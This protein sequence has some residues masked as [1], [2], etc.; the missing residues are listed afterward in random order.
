MDKD[1]QREIRKI[2]N[3]IEDKSAD[4]DYI[5]RG[6]PEKHKEEPHCGK[7]SSSLWRAIAKGL[8]DKE[9]IEII[10][11]KEVQT[12]ILSTV[13]NYA[14]GTTSEG[15]FEIMGNL[16]HY[17][18]KT[19]LIDFTTDY[20]IA[21]FFAC[22]GSLCESG[23]VILLEINDETNEKYCIKKPQNPI[24]RVISQKSIFVQPP[25]GFIAV[26]PKDEITIPKCLKRP[27]LDYL[28]KYHDISNEIIYNDFH[29]FIKHQKIHHNAYI[30]F[31]I[32]L[33]YQFGLSGVGKE[34]GRE[35]RK[36]RFERAIE[37]FDKAIEQNPNF[38]EAYYYRGSAYLNIGAAC[39][40]TKKYDCAIKDLDEAIRLNPKYEEAYNVR[41]LVYHHKGEYGCAIK[42]F[43][44]AV[45]L[46][47]D[48]ADAYNN[49]GVVYRDKGEYDRA[50]Q[51]FNRAIELNRD[52]ADA[53]CHRGSAY[54]KK[55]EFTHAIV[56]LN[57]TIAINPKNQLARDLRDKAQRELK[58]FKQKVE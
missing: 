37:Y 58:K 31:Y 24:N 56:D 17:G 1:I 7:V 32:G 5:Y 43:D 19:N 39:Q 22:D 41:G 47:R 26:K 57:K 53:Y 20:L 14:N 16:Q 23:R 30:D 50:I 28:R 42:D 4:G 49:R 55:R 38:T 18:G 9:V 21:L 25:K 36:E 2:I 6:E 33:S 54:Y 45:E 52:Y 8:P 27:M 51:D 15:E 44:R 12:G 29:G 10:N 48:Y 11:T 34:E 35:E 46:N 3:E 13:Q 40:N